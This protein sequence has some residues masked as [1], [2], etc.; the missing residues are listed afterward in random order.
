MFAGSCIGVVCLAIFLEFLR[1]SVKE[2][3]RYLVKQ[4]VAQYTAGAAA[5]APGSA[6]PT[7]ETSSA[8]KGASA[9]AAGCGVAIP[10]LRPKLWQQAVRSFLHT[11]QFTV[12]YF[13]ML[14]GKTLLGGAIHVVH[15]YPGRLIEN[16][17]LTKLLPAMYYNVYVLVSI[18]LGILVGN[19]I[20]G[21]ETLHPGY[22]SSLLGR[23]IVTNQ[24]LFIVASRTS[25]TR[26]PQSAA[27][28]RTKQHRLDLGRGRLLFDTT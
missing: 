15:V 5:A 8:G 21:F 4:H 1:R 19:L 23:R 6:S 12:A 25:S 28:N 26:S 9:S 24:T 22:V 20:L 10:P 16:P 14:L 17:V 7:A 2:W 13:I 27:G 11:A 3:D 18:F